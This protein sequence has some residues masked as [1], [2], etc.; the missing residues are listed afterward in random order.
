MANIERSVRLIWTGSPFSGLKNFTHNGVLK[1]TDN[2]NG[3][4]VAKGWAV[5]IQQNT[6]PDVI[7]D[8]GFIDIPQN[9]SANWSFL[10]GPIELEGEDN[11]YYEVWCATVDE[12]MLSEEEEIVIELN[13][14]VTIQT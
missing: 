5:N 13:W 6:V 10:F 8:V 11:N 9:Q 12:V 14:H 2:T 4:P 3:N 1:L 7:Q